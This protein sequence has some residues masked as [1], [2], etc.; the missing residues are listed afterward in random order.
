MSGIILLIGTDEYLSYKAEIGQFETD[1]ITNAVQNG[2]SISA[3]FVHTWSESGEDTAINL[4]RDA[5]DSGKIDIRW[6]HADTLKNDIQV[7]PVNKT[8]FGRITFDTIVSV[9]M[10]NR[11][12]EKFLYTYI[13]VD[14]GDGRKGG[15]ELS[16]PLH[17]FDIFK[18]KMLKRAVTISTMLA[19]LSGIVL[20]IFINRQIRV[21]LNR[22]TEHAKRIG[23]GDFSPDNSIRGTD[24]LSDLAYSM[25]DMCSRLLIAKEKIKFEYDARLKTIDQLRH[26]ERL[27]TF[28]LI[29]AGIAHEI[30]TP[31]NVVDGRAKM[32]ISDGLSDTEIKECAGIIKN[33][34]ERM[35]VIISQLLDFT[36]QPKRH[37]STENVS[38]LINQVFQLLHPMASKQ[39]VSFSLSRGENTTVMVNADVGQI[40]QVLVNLLMNSVQAMPNGGKVRVSLSNELQTAPHGGKNPPTDFLKI[41]IID[42]GEGICEENLEHIF[43]PFFTTKQIGTGTGLGLSI[44]HGIVEDHGGWI[45]VEGTPGSGACFSVYLPMKGKNE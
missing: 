43:T 35:T 30:G 18:R 26:T 23:E 28:G 40:Q 6:V 34:A 11:K 20:F 32:I 13:P 1:M 12:G 29:S 4:V 14:V 37:I 15:L 44:V 17:D 19:L 27:S 39:H 16:Q 25:N 24:E 9:K 42:E 45:E 21:P 36:R 2:N 7:S 33:Q 5:N 38:L 22:L 41:R 8:E 3:M 10:E 31:L